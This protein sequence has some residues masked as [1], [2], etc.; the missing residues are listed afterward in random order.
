MIT[1]GKMNDSEWQRV[2]QQMTMS[3]SEWRRI[4]QQMNANQSK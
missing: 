4:L 2:V 1:S 3:D